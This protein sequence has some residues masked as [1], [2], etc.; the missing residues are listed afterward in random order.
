MRYPYEAL[1]PLFYYIYLDV[2]GGSGK[3]DLIP[4][5]DSVLILESMLC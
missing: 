4:H 5:M 2:P 3:R 1:N